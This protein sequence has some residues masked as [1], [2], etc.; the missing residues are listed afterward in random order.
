MDNETETPWGLFYP[1]WNDHQR[2]M[3]TAKVGFAN[4]TLVAFVVVLTQYSVSQWI[5]FSGKTKRPPH[6]SPVYLVSGIIFLIMW[7]ILVNNS[8]GGYD[9]P[10]AY[11]IAAPT[12]MIAGI[13]LNLLFCWTWTIVFPPTIDEEDGKQVDD[14]NDIN[15]GDQ[16][17]KSVVAAEPVNAVKSI[18]A[19]AGEKQ[20]DQE[21]GKIQ[22]TTPPPKKKVEYINNIKIFLTNMVILHHV[23][24][25][26][27]FQGD[28]GD[29]AVTLPKG[30]WGNVVMMFFV[31]INQSYFMSLF[32][33]FS[34]YFVPKSFDKKGTYVFLVERA[35]RFGIPVVLM[36]FVIVPYCL[37]GFGYLFFNQGD[38]P[39]VRPLF[40]FN[41]TW[42]LLQLI[43]FGIA[44]AFAC[45]N[46]WSPKISCPSLWGFFGIATVLGLTSG[47]TI[48][49]FPVDGSVINTPQFW[50]Q[51]PTYVVF[52]FGGALAQRNNWME[53]IKTKSRLA[54]YLWAIISILGIWAVFAAKLL[55]LPFWSMTLI[56]GL[57]IVGQCG[58]S[59]SLAVTVF[60]MDYVD[61]SYFFTDFFSK[62]MY[63]AYIIQSVFP[64]LAATKCWILVLEATDNVEYI[65]A[66]DSD[67]AY[68][69][70]ENGNLALPGFLFTSVI[71][72]I[73]I[74]P[75]AYSIRSI[76]GFSQVL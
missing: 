59:I 76:P 61:K 53:A 41:V 25:N 38:E 74:W 34:G 42:F 13:P 64:I 57:V 20:G 35:K 46:G 26:Y 68:W 45:G 43:V 40:N 66:T 55:L 11:Y 30:N 10:L 9:L 60:F 56:Q 36:G 65:N 5:W 48:M 1:N 75:M 44:Y 49:F 71:T 4:A 29:I 63:T 2:L 8:L 18:D 23:A 73:I 37:F 52:F 32:F 33:F 22:E 31:S 6:R 58:V 16:D 67:P 17:D 19:E 27:V 62:S 50:S 69:Y 51:Y 14:G 28:I 7:S 3:Y 21:G 72:L 39:F 70:I 12:V 54:I 24:N 47:V 15:E